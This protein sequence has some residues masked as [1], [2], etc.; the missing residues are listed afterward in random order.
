MTKP[1][2]RRTC[3][4]EEALHMLSNVAQLI[5]ARRA[6]AGEEGEAVTR[7]PRAAL[8]EVMRRMQEETGRRLHTLTVMDPKVDP[9]RFDIES[10][11]RNGRW[12]RAAMEATGLLDR[13]RPI[14]L[15][16]AHYAVTQLTPPLIRPDTSRTYVNSFEDWWWFYKYASKAARWLGYVPFERI[17]DARNEAPIIRLADPP[18][19]VRKINM[20]D[21]FYLPDPDE[22]RPTINFS[23]VPTVPRQR[24]RFVFWGEKT[25]L[26]E[27]LGPIAETFGADLYLPSGESTDTMLHTMARTAAEDGREMLVF[28][29]ADCDPAGYQMSVSIAHKLR[30]FKEGGFFPDLRFRLFVPALTV[31]QVG[32]LGLPETPLKEGDKRTAGWRTRYGVEQTEID[33]LA[34]LQP[35]VLATIAQ[36]AIAPFYDPTLANRVSYARQDYEEAAQERFDE[37][38]GDRLA[39]LQAE[40]ADGIGTVRTTIDALTELTRT[41]EAEITAADAWPDFDMPEPTPDDADAPEPLV[42]SSMPLVEAI[43]VLK[44]RK[45]YSE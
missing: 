30:A 2:P 40:A 5:A 1:K 21:S 25:S 6:A 16:G 28:V 15:R 26:D 27:V 33:A 29:F 32:D 20:A 38:A 42:S 37:Q 39:A 41:I 9:F 11:H 36:E 23:M 10:G 17:V 24:D 44:A 19:A 22:L 8:G 3:G 14:H 45:D 7:P 43:D 4:T 35:D 31:E 13:A 18:L 12:F 34:T